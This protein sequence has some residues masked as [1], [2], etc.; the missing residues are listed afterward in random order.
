MIEADI[1]NIVILILFSI[2]VALTAYAF[3]Y[4]KACDE[5]REEK[6]KED[7]KPTLTRKE[8]LFCEIIGHGYIARDLDGKL[9]WFMYKPE[10]D[11]RTKSWVYKGTYQYSDTYCRVFDDDIFEYINSDSMNL[12]FITWDDPEPWVIND[13]LQ[14]RIEG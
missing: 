14:L 11:D 13:L 5:H 6:E 8:K 12:S 3:G 1:I 7:G 4:C 9:W 10:K 2:L